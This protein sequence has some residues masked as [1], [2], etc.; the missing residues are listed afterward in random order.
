MEE[1][2]QNP[3]PEAPQPQKQKAPKIQAD[4]SES[5]LAVLKDVAKRLDRSH[6]WVAVRLIMAGARSLAGLDDETFKSK[7]ESLGLR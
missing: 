3:Q 1:E 7:A 5:D 2:I 4:V 6:S